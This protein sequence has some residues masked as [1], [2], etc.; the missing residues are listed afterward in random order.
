MLTRLFLN[1]ALLLLALM[2]NVAAALATTVAST[3]RALAQ[4]ALNFRWTWIAA[5]TPFATLISAVLA[6]ASTTHA[7][8]V[9]LI[10]LSSMHNVLTPNNA[11]NKNAVNAGEINEITE[12]NTFKT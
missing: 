10:L 2:K 6:L 8:M 5:R 7:L 9:L 3:S 4:L 11:H 12:I 1:T